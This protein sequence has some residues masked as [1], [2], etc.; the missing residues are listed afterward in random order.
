M[1]TSNPRVNVT[2]TPETYARLQALSR[3]TG[4]SMSGLVAS[5]LETQGEVF[6]RLVAVLEAAEKA[7]EQAKEV[8]S[9]AELAADLSMAQKRIEDQLGIMFDLAD[10]ATGKLLREA[11]TITRRKGRGGASAP[12]APPPSPKRRGRGGDPRLLTGG[13][14]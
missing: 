10:E 3:V 4:N 5:L 1:P 12:A 14:K 2:L 11:E 13:S 9:G 7:K 8:L 6:D